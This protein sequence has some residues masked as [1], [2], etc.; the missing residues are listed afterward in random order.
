VN[1][2]DIRTTL[3][4]LTKAVDEISDEK[5]KKIQFALFNLVEVLVKQNDELQTTVQQQKDE[6]NRL[7]G[8]QGKPNIRAQKKDDGDDKNG[9]G[10]KNH[11]SEDERK[12]PKG[13]KKKKGK[14]KK[15]DYIKPDRKVSLSLNKEG[16]PDDLIFKGYETK[17]FQD[18]I[19][20]TDNVEFTQEVFYS[21][22]LK[23]TF[24]AALPQG[25]KGDF[26]PGI[27]AMVL[28]M[29]HDSKVTEPNIKRYLK[30]FGIHISTSTISRMITDKHEVFHEEKEDIVNAGLKSTPHQH[31][32]DTSARV[33]GK[34]YYT[35]V[36]CNPY[37]TAFF[38]VP[39][40]DRLTILSILCR[41]ELK[42]TF[43][44]ES[45]ELMQI[46]GLKEN[47]L[48]LIKK[49]LKDGSVLTRIEVDSILSQLFS[50]SKRKKQKKNRKI[51]LEAS[52]IVFYRTSPYAVEFLVCD[53]APQFNL[54]ATHKVLCWIHEGRHY[55]KLNP[56][57][58]KHREILDKFI[59]E[60]WTFYRKLL[61]Y[62]KHPMPELAK[63]LDLEF[64]VLFSTIT[65]YDDLDARI[66]L[67]K[68]KKTRLML[69][70]K[71]PFLPLHNNISE[72][73]ARVQTRHR[74]VNL[75]TR[76]EKG[77]KSK[78]TFATIVQTTRKLLVNTYEYILDRISGKCEMPSLASLIEQKSLLAFDS[79]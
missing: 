28:S 29:Y 70:L 32:D 13:S 9:K 38:T 78:D 20:K 64:D 57:V 59:A 36:L 22:S 6:I 39:K 61:E 58:P 23:K 45:F 68:A 17:L 72:L 53:D 62:K 30:T 55:K 15:K 34:N 44:D 7:K 65:G 16:L 54:I 14:R 79:S 3:D 47:N 31:M 8:E 75:Q 67:T 76:N 48:S 52:A 37:Y 42:F 19:I 51:I 2:Q 26:G 35:Q 27:R 66:G 46:L 24:V 5:V 4:D 21:P 60:F 40:K 1:R 11:S 49:M 74:D 56:I 63:Q 73:G 43:N 50:S 10:S 69:V 71:Y 77:T 25:Y 41:E 33:N 12:T 18:L